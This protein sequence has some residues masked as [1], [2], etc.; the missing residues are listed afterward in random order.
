MTKRQKEID[1]LEVE[2]NKIAD[3]V[4]A[5]FCKRIGIKDIR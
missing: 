2:S 5:D 4:F 3:G 1:I